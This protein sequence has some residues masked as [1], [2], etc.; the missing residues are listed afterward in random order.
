MQALGK[1]AS[2]AENHRQ[3]KSRSAGQCVLAAGYDRMSQ[4]WR[5][6]QAIA[7]RLAWIMVAHKNLERRPQSVEHTLEVPHHHNSNEARHQLGSHPGSRV[8]DMASG[9]QGDVYK[10]CEQSVHGADVVEH[11]VVAHHYAAHDHQEV[12]PPHHL[13]KAANAKVLRA[14]VVV[15][16]AVACHPDIPAQQMEHSCPH[17]NTRALRD[18]SSEADQR[19]RSAGQI[20]HA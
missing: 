4:R 1:Q 11:P 7:L 2:C 19:Y 17:E 13:C 12:Q 8:V 20:I 5:T 10:D 14:V 3:Y 6:V 16:V 15:E 9:C 18:R